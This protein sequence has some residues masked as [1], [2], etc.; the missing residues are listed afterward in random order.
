MTNHLEVGRGQAPHEAHD[1]PQLL[2]GGGEDFTET[3]DAAT[4]L[5]GGRELS[6]EG[7]C[8]G[9]GVAEPAQAGYSRRELGSTAKI[10]PPQP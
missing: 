4:V 6:H 9:I 2:L 8:W 5:R 3:R 10:D 7:S 1:V